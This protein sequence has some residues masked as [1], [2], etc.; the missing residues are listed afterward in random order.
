MAVNKNISVFGDL[1]NSS[2]VKNVAENGK[3][4]KV[5][6]D[7][8]DPVTTVDVPT[9]KAAPVRSSD[10]NS[11]ATGFP[12]VE[13]ID[14]SLLRE[15][16]NNDKI[17]SLKNIPELAENIK[18]RGITN[19]LRVY[20]MPDSD[21]YL[22]Q[23]GHRRRRAALM[24]GLTHV[25]AFVFDWVE[26]EK[27]RKRY[28]IEENLLNRD[29]SP[30]ETARELKEYA[31][32]LPDMTEYNKYTI[33]SEKT[34]ISTGTIRRYLSLTD[35]IPE[36]QEK[37]ENESYS[38]AALSEAKVMTVEQQYAFN[39]LLDDFVSKYG[40]SGLKQNDILNFAKQIKN[41]RK[42]RSQQ[43][44]SSDQLE[45]LNNKYYDYLN[46]LSV[47]DGVER[48]E[49]LLSIRVFRDKLDAILKQFD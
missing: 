31:D 11:P 43:R 25:P 26:D 49:A 16:E 5:D 10:M 41:K 1:L 23:A 14:I 27:L 33:L 3:P 19:P 8:V 40:L 38:V 13:Q 48:Q 20:K 17:Y 12:N 32:T 15:D 6:P 42:T 30:M 35:M 24:A 34:G 22:I 47:L 28:L 21:N 4:D 36:L 18:K 7:K 2:E 9:D 44:V 45:R 37:A 46:R 29:K 39:A